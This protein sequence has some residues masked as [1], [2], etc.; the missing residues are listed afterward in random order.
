MKRLL[1]ISLVAIALPVLAQTAPPPSPAPPSESRHLKP[2]TDSGPYQWTGGHYTYDAAGDVIGIDQQSF[3][4]DLNGR[5]VSAS[6]L[7]PNQS[8]N[9]N[10][11]S[12]RTYGYDQF[13]NMTSKAADSG[14]PTTIAVS[15]ATNRLTGM[16]AQY[17]AAGNLTNITYAGTPYVYAYDAL[18]SL[19]S[20]S[21]NNSSVPTMYHIYTPSDERLWTADNGTS[22]NT[23]TVR[24]LGGNALRQIANTSSTWTVN[25]D[26]VY[27]DGA[28]LEASLPSSGTQEH[29]SLDHLGTPRLT[30]A[31]AGSVVGYHVYLPFGEEWLP[32]PPTPSAQEGNPKKFTGHERDRDLADYAADPFH[33]DYMHARFYS[34]N[35]ARFLTVDPVL[36]EDAMVVPQ[37][38]NRYAYV[39]NS[40]LARIDRDGRNWFF[41]AANNDWEWHPGSQ[42]HGQTSTYTHIIVVQAIGN[43]AGGT[44][45]FKLT[46]YNQDK[47][48]RTSFAFS[49]GAGNLPR[50]QA[51]NYIIRTDLRDAIGP[52]YVNSNSPDHNPP[53]FLG[54]QRIRG[55]A[56]KDLMTGRFYDV[57]AAYGSMRARLN[58]AS[59][60]KDRGLYFHG[61]EPDPDKYPGAGVTHGCLCYGT[62]YSI[63]NYLWAL[64]PQEVPVAVDVPAKKP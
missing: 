43:T 52:N 64:P 14:T 23:F 19:N 54:I 42:W 44:T 40:P 57:H 53:P 28:M 37:T 55:D 17:D 39:G 8:P 2:S 1:Q 60:Q 58:P 22:T 9:P 63:I 46:M 51:G 30:T 31:A 47:A 33:L 6:V 48:V 61:Q 32:P 21:I 20:E 62:D 38:W 36:A 59:G 11:Y 45:R 7:S 34:S 10:Y 16:G 26:Y 29:Y 12:T 5:L 41:V 18:G 27:R 49:G 15:A 13:G 4:Y 50:I 3:R 25:R 35:L 56:L 24:D